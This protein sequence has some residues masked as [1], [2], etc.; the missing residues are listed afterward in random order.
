MKPL[1][2]K[3]PKESNIQEAI[4]TALTEAGYTIIDKTH[5]SQFSPGWPDLFCFKP[6]R[7][8]SR[9]VWVEVKRPTGS[10]TRAQVARFTRWDKAGLGVYVLTSPD[11]SPLGKSPNWKEFLK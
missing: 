5:G 8:T 11:L 4:V 2:K 10:F 1:R 3:P 7:E 6:G 9:V